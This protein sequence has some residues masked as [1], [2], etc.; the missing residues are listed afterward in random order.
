MHF[1]PLIA[2]DGSFK[3]DLASFAVKSDSHCFTSTLPGMQTIQRAELFGILA[4]IWVTDPLTSVTIVTDSYSSKFVIDSLWN[5]RLMPRRYACP[6][7][8]SIVSCILQM[9]EERQR[10]GSETPICWI[11]SHTTGNDDKLE[12]LLNAAADRLATEARIQAHP[13]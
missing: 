9:L 1:S 6:A 10:S 5:Q 4:A 13:I 2:S 7:N 12:Y 11:P 3:D 8:G